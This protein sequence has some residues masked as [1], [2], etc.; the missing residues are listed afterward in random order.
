MATRGMTDLADIRVSAR[1]SSAMSAGGIISAG[2]ILSCTQALIFGVDIA[3][4]DRGRGVTP[5]RLFGVDG[6]AERDQRGLVPAAERQ[7]VT[8]ARQ[9]AGDRAPYSA[10]GSSDH[11]ARRDIKRWPR[12]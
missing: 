3:G 8:G 4:C 5:G 6:L 12:A 11:R 9:P 2:S 1:I 10:S 7:A